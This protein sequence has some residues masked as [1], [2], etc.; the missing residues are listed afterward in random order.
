ME[1]KINELEARK[2]E[3]ERAFEEKKK[4]AQALTNDIVLME[5]L[6]MAKR[7]HGK[8]LEEMQKIAQEH[9]KIC[10]EI[11]AEKAKK[12]E[13]KKQTEGLS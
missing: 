2:A 11:D 1:N 8:V 5:Q 13:V 7:E 10:E 6:I 12:E 9:G 4:Q 3:L